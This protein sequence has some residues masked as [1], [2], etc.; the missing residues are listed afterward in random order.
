MAIAVDQ[1]DLPVIDYDA[2][3]SAD[4]RERIVAEARS[5]HWLAK[6]ALFGYTVTYGVL[7]LVSSMTSAPARI[8][9]LVIAAL[10]LT[11][12]F[13]VL[14]WWAQKLWSPRFDWLTLATGAVAGTASL[15]AAVRIW[16][17]ALLA[18]RA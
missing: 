9:L 11:G 15:Y 6:N 16:R 3:Q 10:L 5:Q 8:R 13:D 4:T 7:A 18:K 17:D 14:S 1:L 12:P 2:E